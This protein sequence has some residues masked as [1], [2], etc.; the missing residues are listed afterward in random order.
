MTSP[1]RV[2]IALGDG[3]SLMGRDG[4]IAPL[5]VL[6]FRL[7][8][9]RKV[10]EAQRYS[11]NYEDLHTVS[12]RLRWCRYRLGLMQ[13]EV[14]QQTGIPLS[15]YE[16]M[17]R[18]ACREYQAHA[19]DK[20]AWL[21]QVPVEDLLDGYSRFLFAGPIDQIRYARERLG[22]SRKAFAELAGVREKSVRDWEMGRKKV[23]KKSWERLK[24]NFPL[25]ILEK[26]W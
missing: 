8:K 15:Q 2:N 11:C 19:V 24:N 23:S 10:S 18:G 5:Y 13:K 14:A 21:Y 20:L 25:F 7:G 12:E 26:M 3:L 22:L 1:W 4:R 6:S 16:E 9:V 17:E